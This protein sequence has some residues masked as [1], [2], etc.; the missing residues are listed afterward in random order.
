MQLINY[1]MQRFWQYGGF[2]PDLYLFI[3]LSQTRYVTRGYNQ[4]SQTWSPVLKKHSNVSEA[5]FRVRA[6]KAQSTLSRAQRKRNLKDAFSLSHCIQGKNI[7]IIDDVITTG[8]TMDAA[9]QT[10]LDAG[11]AKVWA[12]ATSLTPLL[13]K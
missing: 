4:V 7:A 1:Q 3:P 10:C 12:F 11:A 13:G 6:T 9:A 5:L 8:S 2:N